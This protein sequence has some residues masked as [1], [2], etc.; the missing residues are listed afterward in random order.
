[1]SGDPLAE[2][3]NAVGHYLVSLQFVSPVPDRT[4]AMA[5]EEV[6][7]DVCPDD[8]N[9]FAV[10]PRSSK[11]LQSSGRIKKAI[12][13]LTVIEVEPSSPEIRHYSFDSIVRATHFAPFPTDESECLGLRP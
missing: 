1:M 3:H 9:L 4:V 8:G 5:K 12:C 7:A 10:P 6:A 13:M 2:F 11:G